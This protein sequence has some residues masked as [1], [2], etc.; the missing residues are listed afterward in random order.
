MKRHLGIFAAAALVSATGLTACSTGS[1]NDEDSAQS[2][3]QTSVEE[4]AFPVTIKHAFGETTIDEEPK[5]VA[6]LGWTDQDHALALGVVPVGA[7]E[8]TWG[9]NEEGSTDWFD[10]A[11]AE[12]DG[13][14]PTRYADTDGAPV[15]EIAALDPDVILATNS[16]I[17]EEE[18]EKLSEIADVVVYPEAP[19][20]TPWRESLEIV[21]QALGRP[22][23]AADL[24]EQ[25]ESD[26]E[27][28]RAEHPQL[29]DRSF[30][31]TYLTSTDLS[32]VG[33]YSEDDS[34][35]DIMEDFGLETPDWVDGVIPDNAFFGNVSAEKADTIEADLVIT[36]AEDDA[37]VE[38]FRKD[39]LLGRIPAFTSGAYVAET[40]KELGLA[41]TNPTP[42]S[43][44]V[45][46]NDFLPKVADA[47]G[48]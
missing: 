21:G 28:A 39:R 35:V 42:L 4:G 18:Y 44:P 11:L 17:T 37:E 16:G 5:R 22:A 15:A 30:V 26:I 32:T 40:D 31:F 29:E 1:T 12:V 45:I 25:A 13:E 2:A 7:T 43:L 23:A 38:K 41:V 34:R 33:I 14:A 10:A 6:T 46:I 27:A 9:G 48:E 3:T 47:I 20:V 24:V 8:M 19:W 36:Y